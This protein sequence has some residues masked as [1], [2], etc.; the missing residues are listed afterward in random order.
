MFIHLCFS[1]HVHSCF[2]LLNSSVTHFE[3]LSNEIIYETKDVYF[4]LNYI[5]Q[6]EYNSSNS[7]EQIIEYSNDF[8]LTWLNI[9]N[10]DQLKFI[11]IKSSNTTYRLTIPFDLFLNRN[12]SIRF[13]SQGLF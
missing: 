8:G 9:S 12:N 1:L 11:P 13:N 10:E 7:I 2:S 4:N 3:N 5:F 6:I